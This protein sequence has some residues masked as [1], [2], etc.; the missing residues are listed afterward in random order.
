MEDF[1]TLNNNLSKYNLECYQ[2]RLIKRIARFIFKIYNNKNSPN[3]LKMSLITNID[4]KT[5]SYDLRNKNSFFIQAKGKYNNHMEWTFNYFYSK[6]LNE[7]LLS[8]LSLD[9][10]NF[11]R[12]ID[13]NINL[14]FLKFW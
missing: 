9:P 11:R 13:N 14:H 3:G 1:N 7:F 4:K 5:I 2:H 10:N 12:R 6:F 8:D